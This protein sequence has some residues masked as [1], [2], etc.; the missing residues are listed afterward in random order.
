MT[1]CGQKTSGYVKAIELL[2]AK[3]DDLRTAGKENEADQILA[4]L[5]DYFENEKHKSNK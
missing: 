2:L 1:C 3:A 4:S 5:Y